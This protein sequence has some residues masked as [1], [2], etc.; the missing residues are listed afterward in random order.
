MIEIRTFEGDAAEIAAFVTRTWIKSYEGRMPVPLW[1]RQFLQR[2]LLPEG[3][4][5]PRDYLVAAYDGAR[6]VGFHP[7]RP[8]PI[9]LHGQQIGGSMGSWL[10]VDPEYRR[11]GIAARMQEE[12]ERRHRQ[13]GA[14]VN[15][16]YLYVRSSRSMGKKFWATGQI[17][18]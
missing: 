12:F 7:A 17:S 9:R 6:L 2:D 10:T 8:F 13:R 15:F 4:H 16:G 3:D 11:Q 1:S 18:V 14:V 5:D